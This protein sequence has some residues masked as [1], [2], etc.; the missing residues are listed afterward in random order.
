MHASA[1]G[2]AHPADERSR[3]C[4]S[5]PASAWLACRR[6]GLLKHCNEVRHVQLDDSKVNVTCVR[7]STCCCTSEM[8]CSTSYILMCY[9]RRAAVFC[10]SCC[11]SNFADCLQMH[12]SMAKATPASNIHCASRRTMRSWD[13]HCAE[14]RRCKL[15]SATAPLAP[16]LCSGLALRNDC[17]MGEDS[18]GL[19]SK[20][21]DL[22]KDDRLLQGNQNSLCKI[23]TLQQA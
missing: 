9:T 6:W 21:S 17:D 13:Y 10:P 20:P 11:S 12:L 16:T 1:P 23:S 4:C 8:C 14:F 2:K 5:D 19:L 18:K 22:A 15:L 3:P 7:S